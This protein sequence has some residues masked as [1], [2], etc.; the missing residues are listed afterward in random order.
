MEQTDKHINFF[1]LIILI[2]LCE[3][4]IVIYPCCN[5]EALFGFP[6]ACTIENGSECYFIYWK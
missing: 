6:L 4:R 5:R 2:F 1:F 3:A